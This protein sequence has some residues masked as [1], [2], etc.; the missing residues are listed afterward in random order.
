M[1]TPAMHRGTA[2]RDLS[3]KRSVRS[4]TGAHTDSPWKRPPCTQ[5]HG[6]T[7]PAPE[8][9]GVL[10]DPD[11][12]SRTARARLLTPSVTSVTPRTAARQAPLSMAFSWQEYW[13]RLPF[14]SR[15]DRP[16]PKIKL[17]ISCTARRILY[18][19]GTGESCWTVQKTS[20]NWAT[21]LV[22]LGPPGI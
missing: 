13:G 14:P 1:E 21:I 17:V 15:G 6:A 12:K 19:W 11:G 18:H 2:L 7:W 8:A 16:N 10:R 3:R 22:Q 20:K 5:R 4:E 9:L